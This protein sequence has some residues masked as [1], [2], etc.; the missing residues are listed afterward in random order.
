MFS[1]TVVA[2]NWSN[3]EIF[4]FEFTVSFNFGAFNNRSA[5]AS[6]C[7]ERSSTL[8]NVL[9]AFFEITDVEEED[10]EDV[11]RVADGE[12]AVTVEAWVLDDGEDVSPNEIS[13]F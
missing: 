4:I 1:E 5:L 11:E 9:V 8:T 2:I 3:R 12:D 6:T 10:G 7:I 13:F